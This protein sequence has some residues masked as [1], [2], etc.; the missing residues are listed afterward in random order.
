MAT[1]SS[2]VPNIGLT[3]SFKLTVTTNDSIE[4]DEFLN[5]GQGIENR[6]MKGSGWN[7]RDPNSNLVLSFWA[8]TSVGGTYSVTARDWESF[9]NPFYYVQKID[10]EIKN[11]WSIIF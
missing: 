2:E 10:L 5:I 7:Y 8:R 3:S 11:V 4:N 9:D 1:A 6:T